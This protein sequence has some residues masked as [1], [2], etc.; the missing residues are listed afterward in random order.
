MEIILQFPN[1]LGTFFIVLEEKCRKIL[2]IFI[3]LQN[4]QTC[5]T[6]DVDSHFSLSQ[7]TLHNARRTIFI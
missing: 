2:L 1:K 5:R 3:E 7:W 4:L 6:L